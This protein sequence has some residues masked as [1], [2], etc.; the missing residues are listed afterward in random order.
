MPVSGTWSGKQVLKRPKTG[1]ASIYITRDLGKQKLCE[2]RGQAF[3]ELACENDA[4]GE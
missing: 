1:S 3:E 2:L 4:Y